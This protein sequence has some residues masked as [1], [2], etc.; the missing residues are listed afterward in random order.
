LAIKA[1][2]FNIQMTRFLLMLLVVCSIFAC[3][4]GIPKDIIQP[5]EMENILHDIHVVDGYVA[6]IPTP[7]SAK[8]V[9]SPLYKGIFKKYGV[10]SALHAKS[11]TYYYLHPDVL[12]KMY[13]NISTRLGKERDIEANKQQKS[14]TPEAPKELK[15]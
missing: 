10:D 8:K 2:V 6:N 4:P 5:A 9:V 12:T 11:M 14:T 7:D 3:K 13:D 15:N 1:E